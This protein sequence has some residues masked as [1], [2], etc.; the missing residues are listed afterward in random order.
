[1]LRRCKGATPALWG[2]TAGRQPQCARAWRALR[3]GSAAALRAAVPPL[4]GREVSGCAGGVMGPFSRG[5]W[6]LF[7][8]SYGVA[9]RKVSVKIFGLV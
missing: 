4:G 3:A 9:K 1:M 2:S 8:D 7:A 5:N 6:G